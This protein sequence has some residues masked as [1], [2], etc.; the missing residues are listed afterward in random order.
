MTYICCKKCK[1]DKDL[2]EFYKGRLVCKACV[3]AANLARYH[4]NGGKP[5]NKDIPR[6][7]KRQKEYYHRNKHKNHARY[8]TRKAIKNGDLVRPEMCER[9]HDGPVFAHHEDYDRPLDIMW[10]CRKCHTRIHRKYR[11][12]K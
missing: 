5:T 12:S 2:D 7:R 11:G 9:G 8:L 6:Q 10:L 3:S 1:K 4:E